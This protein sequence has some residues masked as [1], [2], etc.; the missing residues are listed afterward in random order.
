MIRFWDFK[1]AG[2]PPLLSWVV[3]RR[4]VGGMASRLAANA[5]VTTGR[6]P[7]AT[8]LICGFLMAVIVA[9]TVQ[10]V[11][12]DRFYGPALTYE[13]GDPDKP[14]WLRDDAIDLI[15]GTVAGAVAI[16]VMVLAVVALRRPRVQP[17]RS[18]WIAVASVALLGV[19]VG[20]AVMVAFQE[21]TRAS[22]GSARYGIA[23]AVGLLAGAAAA[24]LF[25]MWAHRRWAHG[26]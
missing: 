7:L 13:Y 18:G 14:I 3:R 17:I 5:P 21:S 25:N 16:P 8:A 22:L 1:L 6:F 11:V 9:V 19:P 15:S 24:F 23:P 20:V 12:A 10:Y 2:A 26:K 4:R